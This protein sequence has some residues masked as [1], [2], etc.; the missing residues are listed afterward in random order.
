M[1]YLH[2]IGAALVLAL[3]VVGLALSVAQT[4]P[5]AAI[6]EPPAGSVS[7]YVSYTLYPATALT[8]DDTTYSSSPRTFAG[9]DVSMVAEFN[10]V[11]ICSTVDISGTGTI[12][13]TPQFTN[14]GDNRATNRYWAD[15]DYDYWTSSAVSAETYQSVLSADG[16]DCIRAPV[17]GEYLRLKIEH[18]TTDTITPSVRV[19]LRNNGGVAER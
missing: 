9:E 10:S 7:G 6:G 11:D 14:Y 15:A 18:T 16:A 5:A 13:V 3:V 12:T 19:T 2:G 8:T 1:R 17:I 4:Q